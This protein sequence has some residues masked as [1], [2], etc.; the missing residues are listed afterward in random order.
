MPSNPARAEPGGVGRLA[1]QGGRASA[2]VRPRFEALE[3]RCLMSGTSAPI[4]PSWLPSTPP[5]SR[6]AIIVSHAAT[7]VL[8]ASPAVVGSSQAVLPIRLAA[9]DQGGTIAP[10][11]TETV[12]DSWRA[13]VGTDSDGNTYVIVPETHWSHQ[14]FATAQSLP[15]NPYFGVIGTIGGGEPIDLYKLTVNA[16]TAGFQFEL[17]A[18]PSASASSARF[19]LFDSSGRVMGEWSSSTGPSGSLITFALDN[20]FSGSSLFLGVSPGGPNG[21]AGSTTPLGYQLWVDSFSA[22]TDLAAATGAGAILPSIASTLFVGAL[23]GPL[24]SLTAASARGDPS[25]LSTS[26]PTANDLTT[27]FRVS[28][29]SMPT[30]SAQPAGGLMSEGEDS[31]VLNAAATAVDRE[32]T[33]ALLAASVQSHRTDLEPSSRPGGSENEAGLIA[34]RGPGGFPLLG[35]DAIGGWRGNSNARVASWAGEH[36]QQ[37]DESTSAETPVGPDVPFAANEILPV[38]DH[39]A[40]TDAETGTRR[41]RDWLWG[42]LSS[43]LGT[44]TLLTLNALFSNP[45]AGYDVLPS[46]LDAA[47]ARDRALLA[48]RHNHKSLGFRRWSPIKKKP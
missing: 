4:G 21:Q 16:A 45:I 9:R 7:P 30:R 17:V 31:S 14:T 24:S 20:S 27:G 40:G 48:S 41:S 11:G 12:A 33:D 35:A 26:P 32:P 29:G 6:P 1:A 15:D 47:G 34:L 19:W 28:V 2:K 42:T 3:T 43:G 37:P 22:P 46:R 25:A 13:S 39:L 5:S 8:A 23:V 36:T 38:A 10:A 44:V 18:S